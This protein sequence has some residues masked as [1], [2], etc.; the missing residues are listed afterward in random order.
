MES[1]KRRH[2]NQCL[3]CN[4]L[5]S[6]ASVFCDSCLSLLQSQKRQREHTS[7]DV[8]SRV[9][10]PLVL[11]EPESQHQ[12]RE[13]QDTGAGIVTVTS[14]VLKAPQAPS[15]SPQEGY[16]N[17]VEQ[18]MSKL[19]EAARRIA[20]AEKRAR[21][22]LHASRLA[23]LRD[24][25]A[26]IQRHST[27]IPRSSGSLEKE[28]QEQGEDLSS[29]LPDLWP[30]LQDPDEHEQDSWANY[31]DPLLARRFPD[32]A[33]IARIEEEDMR[34]AA[35]QGAVAPPSFSGL[36]PHYLRIAII[37]LT[38]IAVLAGGGWCIGLFH[39]VAP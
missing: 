15:P 5:C 22:G 4:Q 19:S 14:P 6:T 2:M 37:C 32:S 36:S 11:S 3:R 23:P 24:I 20:T 21:H 10:V 9:T 12:L 38:V 7:F 27:P 17:I 8:S 26:E 18:D 13:N 39:L 29:R 25:S 1:R 30:W 33:E 35:A 16:G 31:T 34:R 28:Q